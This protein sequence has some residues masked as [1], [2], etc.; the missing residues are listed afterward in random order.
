MQVPIKQQKA[1]FSPSY[2]FFLFFYMLPNICK[3]KDFAWVKSVEFGLWY[4]ILHSGLNDQ[5]ASSLLDLLTSNLRGG[6]YQWTLLIDML[7]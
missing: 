3:Y 7:L 2:V 1:L 6:G 4:I 5:L